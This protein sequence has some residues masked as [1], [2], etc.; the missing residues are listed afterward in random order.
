MYIEGEIAARYKA[1]RTLRAGR[2]PSSLLTPVWSINPSLFINRIID[3]FDVYGHITQYASERLILDI[4]GNVGIN[5]VSV[6]FL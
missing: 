2:M 4:M 6:T 1:Y 5:T 3:E